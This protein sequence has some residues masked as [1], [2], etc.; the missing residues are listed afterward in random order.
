MPHTLLG[1]GSMAA[2]VAASTARLR[3]GLPP[4]VSGFTTVDAAS[5]GLKEPTVLGLGSALA[6]RGARARRL[7]GDS[8][9]LGRC[10]SAGT[11][12]VLSVVGG[13]NAGRVAVLL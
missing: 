3:S 12:V 7:L 4:Y 1:L 9:V 6:L 2:A 8:M 5:G 13:P 11:E 10:Y